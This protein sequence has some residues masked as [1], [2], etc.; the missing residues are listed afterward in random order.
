MTVKRGLRDKEDATVYGNSRAHERHGIQSV[1][2]LVRIRLLNSC[3]YDKDVQEYKCYQGLYERV[4]K[5]KDRSYLDYLSL[6]SKEDL[7]EDDCYLSIHDEEF[8][9]VGVRS[10]A[11]VHECKFFLEPILV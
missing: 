9:I 6:L 8:P 2:N 4:F 3:C 11:V 1:E 7:D 5:Q 10:V